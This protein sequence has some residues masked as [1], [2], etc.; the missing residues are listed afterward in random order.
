MAE[1]KIHRYDADKYKE[2]ENY[3]ESFRKANQKYRESG[4]APVYKR[5]PI[6]VKPEWYEKIS[7]YA[8]SK[9]MKITTLIKEAV[10]EK[11]K[12]DNFDF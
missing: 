7:A 1:K 2:D 4:K 5:I 3:K 10:E 12:R 11:A 9:G 6:D 8:E